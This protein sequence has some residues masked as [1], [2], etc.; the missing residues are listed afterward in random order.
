MARFTPRGN[1]KDLLRKINRNVSSKK[2]RLRNKFDLEIPEIET[3][4]LKE[5]NTRKEFNQ[6]VKKMQSFTNRYN[7]NYQFKQNEHGVTMTQKDINDIERKLKAENTRKARE[8]NK[9]KK[10]LK[11]EKGEYIPKNVN[12]FNHPNVPERLA[13]FRPHSFN[14]DLLKSNKTAENYKNMILGREIETANKKADLLRTSMIKAM[15]EVAGKH[16]AQHVIDKLNGLSPQQVAEL[17][18]NE[19]DFRPK[20]VY[21][22]EDDEDILKSL[23]DMIDGKTEERTKK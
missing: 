20:Y 3:K 23:E 5:F 13:G 9:L 10:K 4:P 17:Y 22:P 15:I 18:Y 7:T 14:F 16:M 21:S 12:D 1:D 8:Y 11:P 19:P 2:S 6:Y